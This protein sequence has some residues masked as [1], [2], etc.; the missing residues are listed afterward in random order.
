MKLLFKL[1][2]SGVSGYVTITQLFKYVFNLDI[3]DLPLWVAISILAVI[4]I[5][6]IIISI[7]VSNNESGGS[8]VEVIVKDPIEGA[9]TG[10]VSGIIAGSIVGLALIFFLSKKD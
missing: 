8:A 4:I 7:I 5:G 1:L 10:V 9:V 3:L 6:A 2:G